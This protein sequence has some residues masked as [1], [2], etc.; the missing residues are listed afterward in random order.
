M[1]K[2][3]MLGL[4]PSRVCDA[5]SIDNKGVWRLVGFLSLVDQVRQVTPKP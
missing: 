3:V 4:Q 1:L 2:S 5:G